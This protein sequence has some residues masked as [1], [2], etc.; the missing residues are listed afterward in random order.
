[1]MTDNT[2]HNNQKEG[3]GSGGRTTMMTR[4]IRRTTDSG[5]MDNE[6]GRRVMKRMLDNEED[7]RGW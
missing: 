1:M 5:I 4:T 3:G 6:Q 2:A 7:N